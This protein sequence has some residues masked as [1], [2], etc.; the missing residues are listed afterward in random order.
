MR[1]YGLL[2]S[3]LLAFWLYKTRCPNFK[4][5]TPPTITNCGENL[6]HDYI[7]FKQRQPRLCWMYTSSVLVALA[8]LG[9]IVS[10]KTI[11]VFG[12]LMATLIFSKHKLT[13]VN[14]QQ[15]GKFPFLCC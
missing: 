13:I 7:E 2:F 4:L 12:L 15:E 10:G 1:P 8:V 11:I 5:I 3:I 6:Y 14:V 9:H